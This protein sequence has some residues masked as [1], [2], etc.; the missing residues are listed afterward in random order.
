MFFG[1]DEED[2]V[3]VGWFYSRRWF[4]CPKFGK[5][6]RLWSAVFTF[7]RFVRF[8]M[9]RLLCPYILMICSCELHAL[10]GVH[11]P[12]CYEP[13]VSFVNPLNNAQRIKRVKPLCR[14]CVDPDFC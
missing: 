8:E 3:K 1:C 2:E 6:Q 9:K 13:M 10:L 5:N 4:W 14:K 11:L 12:G 7:H